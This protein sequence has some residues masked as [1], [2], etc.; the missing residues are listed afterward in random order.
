M[1]GLWCVSR[2]ERVWSDAEGQTER[3]PLMD[4]DVLVVGAGPVGLMMAA[5]LRRHGVH[6]RII[7]ALV[8][9]ALNCKAV[10][11]Q[12][13]TLE[14]WDQLGI[15]TQAIDAG[16]WLRG[17]RIFANGREV[18]RVNLDKDFPDLPYG[19]LSLPQYESER[20]LTQHVAVFGTAVE[21]QVTLQAFDQ[22]GDGVTANLTKA[23]GLTETVNCRYLVGCDGAHSA[24]RHGLGL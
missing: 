22:T 21:R 14:I 19:F 24:V 12:P 10:G 1:K 2:D 8:A 23:D 6:C 17:L 18:K 5:E 16:I 7:D 20:I 11:I 15:V 13:R 3:R 4:T 9:P